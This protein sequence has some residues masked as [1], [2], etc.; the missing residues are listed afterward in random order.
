M[1]RLIT[2]TA[3]LKP[4]ERALAL[5]S[6]NE[7]E[8]VYASVADK[9][10]THAPD[11]PEEEVDFHYIC[12]VRSHKDGHIYQLDGD[13]KRPIDL[14]PLGAEETLSSACLPIIRRMVHEAGVSMYFSLMA[15]TAVSD[16]E[17]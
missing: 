14:G 10:D 1:A 15:L 6:S 16:Q 9:G 4:D 8:Q 13:R 7:M 3:P 5:E 11:D 2:K 12:F 17:G